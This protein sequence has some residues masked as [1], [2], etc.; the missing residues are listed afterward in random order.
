MWK[1]YW[2]WRTIRRTFG[3]FTVLGPEFRLDKQ[4]TSAE[5]R[6]FIDDLHSR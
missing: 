1:Q 6:G 3:D 5:L 2:T 4:E